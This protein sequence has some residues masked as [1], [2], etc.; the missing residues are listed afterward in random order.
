MRPGL[1]KRIALRLFS[2]MYAG[3]VAAHELRTLFWEMTLRAA[4]AAATAVPMR[5]LPTCRWPIF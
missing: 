2:E 5:L 1:R 4:T 3:K